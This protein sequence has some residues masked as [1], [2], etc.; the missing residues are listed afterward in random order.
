MPRT[1]LRINHGATLGTGEGRATVHRVAP[2]TRP[3]ET[4]ASGI[5]AS[6]RIVFI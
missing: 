3:Q 1:C 2:V 5:S 4:R 6:C